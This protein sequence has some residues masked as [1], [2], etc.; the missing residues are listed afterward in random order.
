MKAIRTEETTE[1][2]VDVKGWTISKGTTIHVM[3]ESTIKNPMTEKTEHW[4]VVRIDNG[5]GDLKY[6]SETAYKKEVGK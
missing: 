3:K 2:I 5:T 1:E 6:M 4:K